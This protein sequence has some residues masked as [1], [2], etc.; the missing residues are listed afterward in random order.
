MWPA[1]GLAMPVARAKCWLGG[2]PALG[3]DFLLDDLGDKGRSER[4][5]RME[6]SYSRLVPDC[7]LG[8]VGSA[9]RKGKGK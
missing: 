9:E 4:V 7:V 6:M 5:E 2:R 3:T 8:I 1:K